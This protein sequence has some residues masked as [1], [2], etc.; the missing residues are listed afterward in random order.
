M[1]IMSQIDL[2][3]PFHSGELEAQTRAGVG[4]VASWTAGPSDP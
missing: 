2:Q 4:D 1:I 3:N